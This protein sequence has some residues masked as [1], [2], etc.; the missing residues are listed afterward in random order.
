MK[1]AG[2]WLAGEVSTE[3]RVSAL[4]SPYDGHVLSEIVLA[5]EQVLSRA[6]EAAT[7]AQ[8]AMA[9]LTRAERAGIL[10]RVAALITEHA[11]ELAGLIRDEMGKPIRYARAEV[12]RAVD[13]F[14]ASADAARHLA[15][16]EIPLDAASPG[17]GRLG[18][19]RRFPVGPIAAITPFNFPLNLVAHKLGP[20]IAA[21]CATVLKPASQTPLS[22]L[23]LA[24]LCGVAGLP[25][26]ALSVIA[27]DRKVGELLV[28]DDRLKALSFTGSAEVGW[29]MKARAG[30]KKVVLELG[31][32]A[33]AI[34]LPDADLEQ[35]AAKVATG[36]FY[37]AGQSCI[38]VQRVLVHEAAYARFRDALTEQTKAT[39]YG[40]PS[41]ESVVSGPLI[42]VGNAERVA[43]W[44]AEAE[45]AGARALVRGRRD[46]CLLAPTL[47]EGAPRGSRVVAEE[48]FGPVI[49]LDR[50]A[51]L[52]E[53]LSIADE[54]R[55]GLQ[56]GIFTND[57]S[58][59]L[60][61]WERLEVG[62]VIHND[63]PAFRVDL[64]PYGGVRDSG[65]GR[66][67]PAYAAE[68][69]T[70]PRLLVLRSS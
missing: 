52:D 29:G 12:G 50:F 18:M 54:T 55:F 48:V 13:T 3:G 51:S 70:E 16:A 6:L 33:A 38:S 47:L 34:V 60:E 28:T 59:V 22:A 41:D 57:L 5:T 19:V 15:G 4:R 25:K 20:A 9:A 42:D 21:G 56:A 69:L 35:A 1:M 7:L 31:G 46:G 62:A 66:E 24:E 39:P 63:V 17:R 40:D 8:P 67:G 11:E 14:R 58:A 23:R 44:V 10:E 37:Q 49:A 53:A 43:S 36:G 30:R 45:A 32:N 68:E 61:A 65:L 26:G 64:M 2:N 27:C